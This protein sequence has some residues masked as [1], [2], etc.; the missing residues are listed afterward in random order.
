METENSLNSL[1]KLQKAE[2]SPFLYD[3]INAK[4]SLRTQQAVPVKW[5]YLTIA[6]LASVLI[7]NFTIVSFQ[8]SSRNSQTL[9]LFSSPDNNTISYE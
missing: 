7:I 4:I 9:E 2:P 3:K 8:N 5:A 6:A 1:Q